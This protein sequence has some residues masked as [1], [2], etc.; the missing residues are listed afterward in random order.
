MI[1]YRVDGKFV[2][3][4]TFYTNLKKYY[5]AV[6]QRFTYEEYLERLKTEGCVRLDGKAKTY[7]YH[8]FDMAHLVMQPTKLSKR[9]FYY[10]ILR[11]YLKTVASK[12]GRKYIVE[13]YGK[14]VYNRVKK[15]AFKI[16]LQYIKLIIKPN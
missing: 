11:A 15:G 12:K 10:N 1:K 6:P 3:E 14:K 16:A 8:Y 2:D 7:E 4:E 13:R 5:D 9:K